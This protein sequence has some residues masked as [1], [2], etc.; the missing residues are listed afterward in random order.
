MP[1]AVCLSARERLSRGV[2]STQK[3]CLEDD[4]KHD[5]AA[6]VTEGLYHF[7]AI[8]VAIKESGS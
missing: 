5:E 7:L 4:G 8:G 1:F 3:H 6:R 2:I